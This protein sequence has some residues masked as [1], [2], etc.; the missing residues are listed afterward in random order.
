MVS[1]SFVDTS[2]FVVAAGGPDA[3]RQECRDF[4]AD[5]TTLPLHASAEAVQEYVFHRFRRVDR[6]KAVAEA[7]RLAAG[8]VLHDFDS[9]VLRDA[10]ELMARTPLGGRDAVHAA[11]ALRAGFESIVSLDVD[12]DAAGVLRREEPRAG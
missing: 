3:R 1:G 12:F 8:L 2:V 4:L 7:R 11:T 10:L 5:A 9:D 6:T